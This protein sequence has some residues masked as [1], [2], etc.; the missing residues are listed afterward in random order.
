MKI[1]DTHAHTLADSRIT[2]SAPPL[3]FLYYK[4][5]LCCCCPVSPAELD[6]FNLPTSTASI[7]RH[8]PLSLSFQSV[9]SMS[10]QLRVFQTSVLGYSREGLQKVTALL[11]F[12]H[13]MEIVEDIISKSKSLVE[14]E[15]QFSL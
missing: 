2:Q 9:P 10:E 6:K 3:V 15:Y 14:R 13:H 12:S 4:V 7:L 11:L 1:K 5:Y 8:L